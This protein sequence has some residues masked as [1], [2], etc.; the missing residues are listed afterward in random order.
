MLCMVMAMT[1]SPEDKRKVEK[2]YEKYNGLMFAVSGK[3]LTRKEDVEDAVFHSWERIIKNIDK[4]NEIDCK[5]TKSFIV[6]ITERI[7]IDHYRKL[8]KERMLSLD[9]YEDSP[10]LFTS[11][12]GMEEYETIEWL[13]SIPKRYS[14]VLILF[15]VN[16]L[17]LKE[18]A[19]AL[20]IKEGSVSSR[21][22]RGREM[23]KKQ[24]DGK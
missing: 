24:L 3:I 1:D 10:Y 11:D 8:K 5:E 23:I 13:R 17:S 2:L 14:E 19:G 7:S 9:E 12:N 6:I 20:G 4:I 16:G 22:S 18:I 15:Y 21:L